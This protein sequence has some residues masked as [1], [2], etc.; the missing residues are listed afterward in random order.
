MEASIAAKDNMHKVGSR[1]MTSKEMY[2][3][4]DGFA[5]GVAYCLAI[6][7]QVLTY[8]INLTIFIICFSFRLV[9][10]KPY[11]GMILCQ[12]N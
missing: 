8:L 9:A 7:K 3:T 1:S 6:L 2:F 12:T 11:I 4:D 5:M 10:L